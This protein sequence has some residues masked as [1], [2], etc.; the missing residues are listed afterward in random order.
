MPPAPADGYNGQMT[1]AVSIQSSKDPRVFLLLGIHREEYESLHQC[2]DQ[3]CG[4]RGLKVVETEDRL[5]C[6]GDLRDAGSDERQIASS[7][8][9]GVRTEKKK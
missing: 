1:S 9:A 6:T 3:L 2:L 4:I 8:R 7:E 5:S